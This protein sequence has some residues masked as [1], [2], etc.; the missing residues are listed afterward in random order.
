MAI[1]FVV[2]SF[3][4]EYPWLERN[5]LVWLNNKYKFDFVIFLMANKSISL[6]ADAGAIVKP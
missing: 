2:A 6:D 5:S 1:N 4:V 3:Q